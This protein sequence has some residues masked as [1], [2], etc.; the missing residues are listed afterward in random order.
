MGIEWQQKTVVWT[1]D[2]K[3]GADFTYKGVG[4]VILVWAAGMGRGDLLPFF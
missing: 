1:S 4:I 2:I 3:S